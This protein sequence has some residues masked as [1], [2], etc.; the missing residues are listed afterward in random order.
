MKFRVISGIIEVET[1]LHIGGSKDTLEIGGMDNPVLRDPVSREPYIPGSS[2]KG[3]MRSI[4]EWHL[5]KVTRDSRGKPC[6]CNDRECAVCWVFGSSNKDMERGP[7]RLLV[8]DAYLNEESRKLIADGKPI[9]ESKTENSINRIT[10]E[11]NPRPLERVIKGV[12]FDFEIVYK[13]IKEED[14]DF[15]HIVP[16]ALRALERDALGGCSSRGCGKIRFLNPIKIEEE[17]QVT[18][19]NSIEDWLQSLSN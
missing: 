15:F 4:M 3:K 7:T 13:I 12:K 17:G 6:S 5:G 1:G 18:N 11:A 14:E 19:F 9:T 10:G 8:R 2:I 16:E